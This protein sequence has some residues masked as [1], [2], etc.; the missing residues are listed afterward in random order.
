LHTCD[1]WQVRDGVRMPLAG[2]ADPLAALAQVKRWTALFRRKAGLLQVRACLQTASEN[3]F[4]V[5][6]TC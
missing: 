6:V 4:L 2:V 3:V 5:E 1:W